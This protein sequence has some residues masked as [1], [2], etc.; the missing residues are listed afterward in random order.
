MVINTFKKK[1]ALGSFAGI[2]PDMDLLKS[3]KKRDKKAKKKKKH[4]RE[5]EKARQQEEV[6][7]DKPGSG[8]L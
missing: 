6:Q 8:F 3:N 5:R 1:H 2:W 4:K 7:C